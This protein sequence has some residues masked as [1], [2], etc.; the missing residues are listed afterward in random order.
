MKV[1]YSKNRVI[2]NA[3]MGSL[4]VVLKTNHWLF[5]DPMRWSDFALLA[6]GFM[7]ITIALKEWFS[8]YFQYNEDS[9][10]L[11]SF[12]GRQDKTIFFKDLIEVKY[13]GGDYQ[14]RTL[15]QRIVISKS[16]MDKK[17]RPEFEDFFQKVKE[18]FDNRGSLQA[19]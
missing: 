9:V 8:F 17:R 12:W 16:Q 11:F 15:D 5:G 1:K 3:F 6:V 13:F 7:F 14:F 19:F 2:F 10:T 18:Q 4:W